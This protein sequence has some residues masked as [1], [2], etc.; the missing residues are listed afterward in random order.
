MKYPVGFINGCGDRV[1]RISEY[2]TV[3]IHNSRVFIIAKLSAE[4]TKEVEVKNE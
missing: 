1:N 3:M 2:P 4:V